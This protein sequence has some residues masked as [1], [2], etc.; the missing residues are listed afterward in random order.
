MRKWATGLLCLLLLAVGWGGNLPSASA[1]GMVLKATKDTYV[2]KNSNTDFSAGNYQ[3]NVLISN[4]SLV[5]HGV[6]QFDLAGLGDIDSAILAVNVKDSNLG[7]AFTLQAY[8]M[9]N[10][11]WVNDQ[12]LGSGLTGNNS[13][14]GL[15]IA[16]ALV[17]VAGKG[18]YELDVTSYVRREQSEGAGKVTVALGLVEQISGRYAYITLAT[19]NADGQ[20][21]AARL[22][23][24]AQSGG[25]AGQLPKP[26]ISIP[27]GLDTDGLTSTR[28]TPWLS[29]LHLA[30]QEQIEAGYK[31]GEASQYIFS[32]DVSRS[33]PSR[34]VFGTDTTG[35]WK[36][37]DGGGTWQPSTGNFGAMGVMAVAFDPD[38]AAVIYAL[39]S[40]AESPQ[41]WVTPA[42]TGLY[43][44][45]D[46]GGTWTLLYPAIVTRYSKSQLIAFGQTAA[47]Q[48]IVYA[49]TQ[50]DGLLKSVDEIAFFPVGSLTGTGIIY[51]VE[52][53]GQKVLAATEQRGVLVSGDEGLTWT[54]LNNGISG[55]KKAIS[56]AVNPKDSGHWLVIANGDIYQTYNGGLLWTL[57]AAKG[58]ISASSG[59][60]TYQKLEFSALPASGEPHLYLSLSATQYNLRVS[61][62]YGATWNKPVHHTELAYMRDNWGFYSEAFAVDKHDS[63]KLWVPFDD[64][65][66]FSGNGGRDF[67]PSSSGFSG[68]RANFFL[69]DPLDEQNIYISAY[70]RGIS[71]SI[72]LAQL[73]GGQRG[74]FPIFNYLMDDRYAPRFEGQKTTYG[75]ARDP[76]NPDH[77]FTSIG[78]WSKVSL[79]ESLDGGLNWTRH[80]EVINT[81][82]FMVLQYHEE[83]SDFI[84]AGRY[85]SSNGGASW[86]LTGEGYTVRAISPVDNDV[87][88][89]VRT[90]TNDIVVSRN[91]GLTWSDVVTL[92]SPRT[93]TPDAADVNSFWVG[94]WNAGPHK[95]TMEPVSGQVLINREYG[96][97]EGLLP[98]PSGNIAVW[99]VAQD[100]HNSQ[101]LIAGGSD[102]QRMSPLPGFF[103]SYD[104][105]E[106]WSL[107]P[108]MEGTGD[109][110]V[111]QFHPGLPQVWLGTSAGTWIYEYEKR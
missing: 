59:D 24:S 75:L 22:L 63:E 52:V 92:G 93:I 42:A 64:E 101:H 19:R 99:S 45:V 33:D 16:G 47:G 97:D 72:P 98:S 81:S 109:I 76:A 90:G 27:E 107:V 68:V 28:F 65:I 13:V 34:L 9:Q 14:I 105:G 37:E 69:F 74:K 55:G 32:M 102:Q 7:Q 11:A 30:K 100:P 21:K 36:S 58:Q 3:W 80:E 103:E 1:G 12:D 15:E 35:I 94:R 96:A 50:N 48:K 57:A 73:P 79:A 43:K 82:N 71:R 23:V 70:D 26:A 61:D 54:E 25:P 17:S 2:Q 18:S 4:S 10:T 106:N 44:S 31:G 89:A 62:D 40:S 85:Y 60:A 41:T 5:Q 104:G 95:I 66:Y 49:G 87:V 8:E 29:Q 91:R 20:D 78:S 110:W 51:D 53:H 56:L 111:I 6:F 88:F 83:D 84:Y 39:G 108:G 77:L 46:G 67:S 38:D 86:Q